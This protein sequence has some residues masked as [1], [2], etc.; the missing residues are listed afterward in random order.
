[1]DSDAITTASDHLVCAKEEDIH[2]LDQTAKIGELFI[3]GLLAFHS[4]NSHHSSSN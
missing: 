3:V 2:F 1:M 4:A